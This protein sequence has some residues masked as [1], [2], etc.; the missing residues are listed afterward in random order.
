MPGRH[1]SKPL[2]TLLATADLAP[3][4]LETGGLAKD[5]KEKKQAV[6]IVVIRCPLL[7][8]MDR[9]IMMMAVRQS[10]S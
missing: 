10:A 8:A 1:P 9:R 5:P 6:R 4:L 7:S 2:S 3:F